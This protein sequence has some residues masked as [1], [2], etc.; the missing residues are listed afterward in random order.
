MEDLAAVPED[1]SEHSRVPGSRKAALP[2]ANLAMPGSPGG[3]AV[4]KLQGGHGDEEAFGC[5]SPNKSV[6]R[7]GGKISVRPKRILRNIMLSPFNPGSRDADDSALPPDDE[8]D[9][10]VVP[11]AGLTLNANALPESEKRSL[12]PGQRTSALPATPQKGGISPVPLGSSAAA[13]PPKKAGDIVCHAQTL[14]DRVRESPRPLNDRAEGQGQQ[15]LGSASSSTTEAKREGAAVRVWM[16]ESGRDPRTEEKKRENP[17]AAG[18]AQ[19]TPRLSQRLRSVSPCP[20]ASPRGTEEEDKAGKEAPKAKAK[21]KRTWTYYPPPQDDEDPIPVDVIDHECELLIV[22][23]D[24]P[25]QP[26]RQ[27]AMSMTAS[28][29]AH[30]AAAESSTKTEVASNN[31][32]LV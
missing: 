8:A 18:P 32:F 13:P 29:R 19:T 28:H 30:T 3:A 2:L 5:P 15:L 6:P 23:R 1:E 24:P 27:L 14:I 11:G 4:R 7:E 20:A 31:T 9:H 16:Q 17:A 26:Q 25:K 22:R 21:K 12:P 10:S